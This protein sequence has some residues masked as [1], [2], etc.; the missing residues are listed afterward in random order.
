MKNNNAIII[1]VVAIVVAAIGFYAGM[2]YDQSK[3]TTASQSLYGARGQAGGFRRG[4]GNVGAN[5]TAVRGQ[6]VASDA[7][8]ITVKLSDGSSK[9][10]NISSSTSFV[11]SSK[12]SES[13]IQNGNT[14]AAFGSS[15]SDGSITATNV[16][17]NP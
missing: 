17:I 7:N 12:A 2:K 6:V 3:A 5:G 10:I 1:V 4:T 14:V 13:D 11:K 15:N 8:S 16:Q 9:I